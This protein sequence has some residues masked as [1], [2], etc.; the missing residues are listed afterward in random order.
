MEAIM[1]QNEALFNAAKEWQERDDI[2]PYTCPDH[3]SEALIPKIEDDKV[4]LVCRQCDY[5]QEYTPEDSIRIPAKITGLSDLSARAL[6][7]H[8]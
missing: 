5:K 2:H 1:N 8:R 6:N 3:S 4:M 7:K